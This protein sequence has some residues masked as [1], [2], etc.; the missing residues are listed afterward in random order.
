MLAVLKCKINCHYLRRLTLNKPPKLEIGDLTLTISTSFGETCYAGTHGHIP[1]KCTQN[2][3]KCIE[4]H[5]TFVTLA[6]WAH[7]PEKT[8]VPRHMHP[9]DKVRAHLSVNQRRQSWGGATW[10]RPT[11]GSPEQGQAP[12]HV[13]FGKE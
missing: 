4:D 2:T 6:R 9:M 7:K 13:R 8:G 1:K 10:G 5:T 3:G 11:P 12:V